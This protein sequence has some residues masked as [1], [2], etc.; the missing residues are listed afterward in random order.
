MTRHTSHLSKGE[1]V[2]NRFTIVPKISYH[3][4]GILMTPVCERLEYMSATP[5]VAE[6]VG[7]LEHGY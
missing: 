7:I 1:D 6:H 3:D 2:G 5:D 4:V